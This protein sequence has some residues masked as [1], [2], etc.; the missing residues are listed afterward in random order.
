MMLN[1]NVFIL[2]IIKPAPGRV[3][4]TALLALT[5]FSGKSS[6]ADVVWLKNGSILLGEISSAESDGIT[7]K[8][9]GESRKIPQRDLLKSEKTL[10]NLKNLKVDITLRDG[11]V[12]K[13]KLQ[14]YDEEIGILVDIDFG[15]LTLPVQS[16][17]EIIDINQ[18]I[19]NS[20]YNYLAGASLGYYVP[21]GSA[22]KF[23]S[24]YT[25]SI[26]F[27]MDTAVMRGL[28]AGAGFSYLDMKHENTSLE[29]SMFTL[30]PYMSYK[31]MDFRNSNN[32]S[33]S[34]LIPFVKLGFGLSYISLKDNRA[35][36]VSSSVS[37]LNPV[38]SAGIGIDTEISQYLM[39]RL[40]GDWKIVPQSSGLFNTAGLSLGIVY[41]F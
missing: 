40:S 28:Y 15:S 23:S 25:A 30:E 33:I 24:S 22:G 3:I 32:G 4:I 12:I 20:G 14:N 7:I 27:E 31:F 19:K 10:E 39:L 11:S 41:G 16:I 34:T 9:F 8:T 37:E 21:S 6:F 13:G 1:L 36:A 2:K 26:F 18:K 35:S 38:M 17:K 29:Y 5:L